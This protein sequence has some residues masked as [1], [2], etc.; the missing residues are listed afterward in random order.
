MT[1]HRIVNPD[2]A[3]E[4]AGFSHA[5]EASGERTL[6]LAGQIGQRSDGSIPEGLVDQFRQALSNVALCLEEAGFPP[7]SVVRMIIYT[8]EVGLYRQS[9][10]P[11]GR[12]YREVFGR[13]YPAMALLGV[14]ELFDPRAKV[15][16]VAT[17]VTR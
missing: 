12:V 10:K 5:V 13:H 6:Y 3:P 8:T 7:T 17:A 16:L 11:L 1:A 15:E 14:G 2:G 9:L 4:A